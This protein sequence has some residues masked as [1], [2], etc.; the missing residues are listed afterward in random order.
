M[1]C[2]FLVYLTFLKHIYITTGDKT[3]TYKIMN[4]LTSTT[5][6]ILLMFII[7]MISIQGLVLNKLA[8][9]VE[10][11]PHFIC[12]NLNLTNIIF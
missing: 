8:D 4:T 6:E 7:L 11:F 10:A 9:I 1:C 2:K 3:E 12:S 5:S